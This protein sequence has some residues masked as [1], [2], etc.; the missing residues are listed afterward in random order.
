MLLTLRIVYR[1]TVISTSC[2]LGDRTW[3]IRWGLHIVQEIV[4]VLIVSL[5]LLDCPQL[6][7]AFF[8]GCGCLIVR[9]LSTS[10]AFEISD[11]N[12]SLKRIRSTY[13]ISR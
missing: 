3:Q 9:H 4:L 13:Q 6:Y 2:T 5:V 1:Y 12:P 8:A 7:A 11:Q 10:L